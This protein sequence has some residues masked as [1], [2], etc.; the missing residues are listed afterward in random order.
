MLSLSSLALVGVAV[1][2]IMMS[3]RQREY[4][5]TEKADHAKCI[6]L[7]TSVTSN[8]FLATRLRELGER[9]DSTDNLGE[10]DR[11]SRTKYKAGG[12]SVVALWLGELADEMD[13]TDD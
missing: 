12:P 13:P 10:L 11:I 1:M 6:A 8:R 4:R 7:V 3:E 2:G 5:D 9:W